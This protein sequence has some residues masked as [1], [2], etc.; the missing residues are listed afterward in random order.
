MSGQSDIIEQ[1]SD[2]FKQNIPR[3]RK[4]LQDRCVATTGKRGG[5]H[6]CEFCRVLYQETH[7]NIYDF[8]LVVA[9]VAEGFK[10]N[11][12]EGFFTSTINMKLRKKPKTVDKYKA[13]LKELM[14]DYH[15]EWDA[16]NPSSCFNKPKPTHGVNDNE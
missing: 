15:H 10:V 3:V 16:E 9:A 1:L 7:I 14:V 11:G 2:H 12:K 8:D 5:V 4:W 13:D 6:P